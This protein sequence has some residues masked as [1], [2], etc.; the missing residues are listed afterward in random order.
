MEKRKLVVANLKMN[1]VYDEIKS[2]ILQ[3]KKEITTSQVVICP[4]SIYIP[5]FLQGNYAL[6]V[7]NTADDSE[8]VYTGEL[9]PKQAYSM[10]VK[11]TIL[12]H[13]ER[14]IKFNEDD[15][16]VNKKVIEA[17]KHNLTVILCV[18]ETQSERAL[19]KTEQVVKR[20]LINCL[21]GLEYDMFHNIVIA[22][23]PVW[24]IGSNI[25]PTVE[26]IIGITNYIKNAVSSSYQ[27]ENIR[28]LYGGSVNEKNIR[29]LN[30]INEVDG[31]L[32]GTASL[33]FQKLTKIINVVTY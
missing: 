31:F 17:I 16:M 7:Q 27:Y 29:E 20:Q 14:R 3:A 33:D 18:G 2:Y 8:G 26:D 9:S 25:T 4:T 19:R 11:Y 22:Y 12:G 23:E 15:L 13:S 30:S 32:V 10:G 28:V 1:F 24:A 21:R 5:Y 6:G